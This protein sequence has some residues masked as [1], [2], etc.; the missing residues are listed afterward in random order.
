MISLLDLVIRGLSHILIPLFL[1]GMAG[2]AVIVVI[3]LAD[4]VTDFLSDSGNE[5]APH[6]GLN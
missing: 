6:D 3:T 2:S 4:D 5:S 1:V